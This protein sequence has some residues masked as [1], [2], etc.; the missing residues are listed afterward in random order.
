MTGIPQ[1][2]KSKPLAQSWTYRAK[3]G[4]PFG[5]VGRYQN[6]TDKKDIVPFFKRNGSGWTTGAPQEPRP[7]FGLDCLANHPREK[8]VFIVEGEKSAAALRGIGIC[9]LTSLGGSGAA[10]KADWTPLSGFKTVILWPDN[11]EPGDKYARTVYQCLMAL[12]QPPEVKLLKPEGL[13][14]G[15]DC[16][17]WL[18]SWMPK[19]NEY[20][21]IQKDYQKVA[22]AWTGFRTSNRNGM[23]FSHSLKT[24][25]AGHYLN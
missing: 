15:G 8:A 3:D 7:L 13:P 11:D 24:V 4:A 21:P 1:T 23:G 14:E 5:V 10:D 25:K 2:F 16:V 18:K 22:I 9:A 6:G 20:E 12:E 17:D 19:W